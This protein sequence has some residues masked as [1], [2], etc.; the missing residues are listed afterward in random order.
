MAVAKSEVFLVQ[1]HKADG[2]GAIEQIVAVA[3]SPDAMIE[4]VKAAKPELR[5]LGWATLEDYE[6]TAAR[7]REA[8]KGEGEWPVVMA[9]G[10]AAG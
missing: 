9:P 2:N 6:R 1:G 4:A 8:L 5:L 7:M 3:E 10:I